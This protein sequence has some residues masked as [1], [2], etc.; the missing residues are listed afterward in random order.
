MVAANYSLMLSDVECMQMLRGIFELLGANV[1]RHI[2]DQRI[3]H[4]I[5]T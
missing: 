2:W 5:C 3:L 1:K 4:V